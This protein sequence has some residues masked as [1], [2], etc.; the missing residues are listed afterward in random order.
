M[1]KQAIQVLGSGCPGCKQLF[2]TVKKIA[3]ELKIE[4]DVE[5]ITDVAEMIKM[6]VIT[7]PVLAINGKPVLT[8]GGYSDKEIKNVLCDNLS[9]EKNDGCRSCG[10]CRCDC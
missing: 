8:G 6:G 7:S 4:A 10:C 5:Y 3:A 1:K 9:K 2:K